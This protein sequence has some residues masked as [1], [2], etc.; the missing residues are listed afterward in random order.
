MSC[1]ELV[2]V[3]L[4]VSVCLVGRELV[5]VLLGVSVCLL[6]GVSVC[7]LLGVSVCLLLG[8][9]VCLLLGVSVCLLL[10]VSVCFLLRYN[11]YVIIQNEML[12]RLHLPTNT[13]TYKHIYLQTHLEESTIHKAKSS[14]RELQII[15]KSAKTGQ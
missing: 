5:Y 7:F 2:Y 8:V 15:L 12:E 13:F 14:L 11:I 4:G 6:L 10:G 9:S 3:L 1:W